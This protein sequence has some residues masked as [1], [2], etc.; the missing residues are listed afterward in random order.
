MTD[1]RSLLQRDTIEGPIFLPSEG[2][3]LPPLQ[4]WVSPNGQA[5]VAIDKGNP[6]SLPLQREQQVS[7]LR[8]IGT[9]GNIP[10][11]TYSSPEEVCKTLEGLLMSAAKSNGESLHLT[12][13]GIKEWVTYENWDLLWPNLLANN[14]TLA[15]LKQ[16]PGVTCWV[17][18]SLSDSEVLAVTQP[19]YLG[20]YVEKST[21]AAGQ[22][23]AG[24]VV[25]NPI[26]V[27]HMTLKE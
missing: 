10:F 5:W 4:R 27:V 23:I 8:V 3:E 9:Q 22:V 18:P 1:I 2:E 6:L 17:C 25:L 20:Q 21:S 14:K 11:L 16:A 26:G 24:M 12:A 7:Y 19:Q 13:Q 15:K